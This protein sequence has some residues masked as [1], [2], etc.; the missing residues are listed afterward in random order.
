MLDMALE[1]SGTLNLLPAR[2]HYGVERGYLEVL[3]GWLLIA[4]NP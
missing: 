2:L 3:E 4:T 1:A